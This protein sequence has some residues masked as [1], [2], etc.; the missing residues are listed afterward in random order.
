MAGRL[1]GMDDPPMVA[2]ATDR[3]RYRQGE[4]LRLQVD[5]VNP[6]RPLWVDGY[7]MLSWPQ[8]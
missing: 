6:G 2:I 8:G 3:A 4:F 1:K 5:Y 7:L